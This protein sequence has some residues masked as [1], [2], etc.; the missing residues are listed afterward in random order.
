MR[1]PLHN[2]VREFHELPGSGQVVARYPTPP[3]TTL[4]RHRGRLITEEFKEVMEHLEALASQRATPQQKMER[5]A[6]LL[7]EL[8]D[9]VY[10]VEGTAVS[11]GLPLEA[12]YV[13]THQANMRKVWPDGTLHVNERGKVIKPPGWYDADMTDFVEPIIDGTVIE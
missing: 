2:L 11:L 9:L 10:V 8:A 7:G 3:G 12:A 5:L 4:A 13:A 1:R 6:D